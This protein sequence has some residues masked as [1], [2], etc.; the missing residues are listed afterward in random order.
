MI[1]Q[2]CDSPSLKRSRINV[3]DGRDGRLNSH[4]RR[5]SVDSEAER[6]FTSRGWGSCGKDSSAPRSK[7]RS[8]KQAEWSDRSERQDE[9]FSTQ[10]FSVNYAMDGCII[11]ENQP[12]Q[13][14][15]AN[16]R[17][18]HIL[19]LPPGSVVTFT[20][21]YTI[22][23]NQSIH[24]TRYYLPT[25]VEHPLLSTA[26]RDLLLLLLFDLG[27]LGLDFAGTGEGSV[28]CI[29]ARLAWRGCRSQRWRADLFPCFLEAR[30]GR[31]SL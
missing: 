7:G 16:G 6:S 8:G 28:N 5:L 11:S 29:T 24:I 12:K 18:T 26:F 4:R 3:R 13:V 1:Q 10:G 31:W 2:Q 19:R 17:M 21:L 9:W 14:K 22:S 20:K 15:R 23:E 25:V 30:R 27:G